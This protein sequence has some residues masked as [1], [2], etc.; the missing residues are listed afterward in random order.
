[1]PHPATRQVSAA[2]S[3]PRAANASTGAAASKRAAVSQSGSSQPMATFDI[4]TVRPQ[5]SPAA[6][7]AASALRRSVVMPPRFGGNR[8]SAQLDSPNSAKRDEIFRQMRDL[9]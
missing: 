3:E 1:M 9:A 4:G 6:A 5:M 8:E 7:R 2:R